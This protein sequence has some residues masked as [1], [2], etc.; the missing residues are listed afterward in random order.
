MRRFVLSVVFVTFVFAAQK[1]M[2]MPPMPPGMTKPSK[3]QTAA[4]QRHDVCAEVPP[5]IIFLPPPLAKA[6]A[7]CLL[8]K[9]KPSHEEVKRRLSQKLKSDVSVTKIEGVE[10]FENLYRIDFYIG[11][12]NT[13]L[14]CDRQLQHCIQ[15]EKV[16]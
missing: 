4:A 11:E 3:D 9:Q 10:G 14:F 13:T 12:M 16:W 2:P 6:R 5:M 8:Q 15:G 7:E 1:S